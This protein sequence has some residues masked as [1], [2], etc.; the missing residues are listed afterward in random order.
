MRFSDLMGSGGDRPS[1]HGE[2]PETV[3]ADAI[4]PYLDAPRQSNPAPQ[5]AAEPVEVAAADAAFAPPAPDLPAP[6]APAVTA[7]DVATPLEP[8]PPRRAWQPDRPLTASLALVEASPAPAA[9]ATAV[10]DVTPFSDDLLPRR[11]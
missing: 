9:T 10:I 4:A 3:I 8:A 7:F 5:L 6:P 1:K 2:E 11:R